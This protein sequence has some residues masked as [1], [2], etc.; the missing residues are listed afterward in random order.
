MNCCY[1]KIVFCFTFKAIGSLLLIPLKITLT[2]GHTPIFV[3]K[4]LEHLLLPGF[5]PSNVDNVG[6]LRICITPLQEIKL[7]SF[8]V[9]LELF[10]VQ[11]FGRLEGSL[12]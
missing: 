2:N 1:Q 9:L 5:F 8:I 12:G 7:S 11:R 10:L 3:Q 4:T 6:K